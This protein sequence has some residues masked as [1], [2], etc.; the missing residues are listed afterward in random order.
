[1]LKAVIFDCDGVIVDSEPLHM[2]LIQE[3]LR[4]KGVS[5]SKEEYLSS[6]LA[7]DDNS[8]FR[9]AL[10]D[11]GC[12]FT[13]ADI[14]KLIE[15]KTGLYK[16]KASKNLVILPGVVEIVMALSQKF[17]LA[18]ASGALRDE[19][20]LMT[21]SA[22]VKQYFDVIVAAEDVENSKPAP[23]AFLKAAA[24]L[25]KLFPDKNIQPDNCLV[26][27]DSKHGIISAQKAGM[28]CVAVGTTYPLEELSSA[29][30]VVPVLTALKVSELEKLF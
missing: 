13:E 17:P 10:K 7:M 30:K 27:E 16:E 12:V 6:Y 25:G 5:V 23:D 14:Q 21:E 3:L 9:Q 26:I 8:C 19:V 1:M 18:V 20:D 15:T 2:S 11:K 28:K 22:G 29:D 24:D 4:E